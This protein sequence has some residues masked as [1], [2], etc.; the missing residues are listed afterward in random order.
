MKRLV[1]VTMLLLG[2]GPA[3]HADTSTYTSKIPRSDADLQ[4]AG[5]YC[6]QMLGPVH[7]GEITPLKYKRC[8]L[9]RGWRYQSTAREHTSSEHTWIDPDTGDTCHDI[10][11]GAGSSC[12]NF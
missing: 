12:G 10:L 8:M 4:A 6:D 11:G 9:S 2:G 5:D 7:N 3:A 1:L